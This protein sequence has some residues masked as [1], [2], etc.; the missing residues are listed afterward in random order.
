MAPPEQ[1]CTCEVFEKAPVWP[2][3]DTAASARSF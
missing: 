1:E 2:N 3:G